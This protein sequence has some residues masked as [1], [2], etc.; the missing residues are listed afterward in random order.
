VRS[1]PS[2][3]PVRQKVSRSERLGSQSSNNHDQL[4]EE[5][6]FS[7]IPEFPGE[8]PR[9]LGN[10]VVERKKGVNLDQPLFCLV[11]ILREEFF[12]FFKAQKNLLLELKGIIL[13]GT[14][15]LF[16]LGWT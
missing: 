16:F 1:L 6:E 9:E 3:K 11:F 4:R 14:F 12:T 2:L 7:R 10:R 8:V 13:L 5:H 15:I